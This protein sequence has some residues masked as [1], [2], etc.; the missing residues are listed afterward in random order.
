MTSTLPSSLPPPAIVQTIDET[1]V[2]ASTI[3][4]MPRWHR[5]DA[6]LHPRRFRLTWGALHGAAADAIRRHYD[7]RPHGTFAFT[8]PRTGEVIV[9]VWVSPPTIQWASAVVATTVS[10]EVEEALAHE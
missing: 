9:A 2:L 10:A 7:D 8:V 3:G 1:S 6:M 4:S 5:P